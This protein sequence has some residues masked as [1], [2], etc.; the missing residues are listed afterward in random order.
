[1]DPTYGPGADAYRD[2]VRAFL[3]EHLPA[4]WKG[5]GALEPAAAD[6][7]RAEWRPTLYEAGLLAPGTG[8]MAFELGQDRPPKKL[9]GGD[10]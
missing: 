5:L 6:R 10:K 3:A 7:F 1:M 2:K 4:D 8:S 9:T